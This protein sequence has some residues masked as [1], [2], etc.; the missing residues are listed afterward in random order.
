MTD[1]GWKRCRANDASICCPAV[2]ARAFRTWVFVC[3]STRV[4]AKSHQRCGCAG[5][6]VQRR[7]PNRN[8][9]ND[10]ELAEFQAVHAGWH[11][12]AVRRQVFLEDARRRLDGN[13]TDGKLSATEELSR[14]DRE[15]FGPGENS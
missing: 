12:G 7:D 13:R 5:R 14:S 3:A 10:A 15:V 4:V 2:N 6:S 11:G 8:S 1:S 9:H